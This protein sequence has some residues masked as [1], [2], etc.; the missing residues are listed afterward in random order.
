MIGRI[1]NDVF[2]NAVKICRPRI[3]INNERSIEDTRIVRYLNLAVREDAS[4][5]GLIMET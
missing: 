4:N 2:R 1:V 3:K 5:T